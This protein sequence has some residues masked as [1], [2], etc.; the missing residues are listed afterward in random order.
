GVSFLDVGETT[1]QFFRSHVAQNYRNSAPA[2]PLRD[3]AAH[4]ARADHRCVG[5]FLRRLLRAAAFV[6]FR[7]EKIADQIL[8]RIGLAEFDDG[9][10]L[11][12]QRIFDC[13]PHPF[14]NYFSRAGRRRISARTSRTSFSV[15]GG[16]AVRLSLWERGG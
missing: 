8:R 16:S 12:S 3:T 10:E 5:N 2:E 1:R 14:R 9:I 6:L 4:Y 15:T 13:S 11:H 7:Q